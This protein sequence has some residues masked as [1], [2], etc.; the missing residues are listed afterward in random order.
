MRSP[1]PTSNSSYV[2]QRDFASHIHLS[3]PEWLFILTVTALVAITACQKSHTPP[4]APEPQSAISVSVQSGGISV[5]TPT[6]EF[7]ILR[8]G[9][10]RGYLK[11]NGRELTMDD[12]Q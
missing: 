7:R 6:A 1:G 8:S 3:A 9:Y 11:L 4:A 12:P 5:N 10:L 2:C